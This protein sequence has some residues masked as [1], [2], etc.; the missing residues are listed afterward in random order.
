MGSAVKPAP[1]P[2]FVMLE[3][4]DLGD[5]VKLALT[6]TRHGYDLDCEIRP[7]PQSRVRHFMGNWVK[8]YSRKLREAGVYSFDP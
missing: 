4:T 2:L 1:A 8:D 3:V 5:R 6:D 7:K